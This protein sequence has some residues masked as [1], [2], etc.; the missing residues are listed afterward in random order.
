MEQKHFN[1]EHPDTQQVDS[2]TLAAWHLCCTTNNIFTQQV[3]STTLAAWHTCRSIL[4]RQYIPVKHAET[5]NTTM[6]YKMTHNLVVIVPKL[7]TLYLS[8]DLTHCDSHDAVIFF[9]AKHSAHPEYFKLSFFLH[10]YSYP[11]ECLV[12]LYCSLWHNPLAWTLGQVHVHLIPPSYKRTWP[13][14][15]TT[16]LPFSM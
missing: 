2:T 12:T 13:H 4:D 10:E 15:L 16:F 5:A 3:D 9:N 8:S 7:Y 11:L 6:L 14:T 1:V